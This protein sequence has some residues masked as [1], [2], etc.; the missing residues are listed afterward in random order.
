MLAK[1][2]EKKVIKEIIKIKTFSEEILDSDS[3]SYDDFV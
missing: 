3:K 1:I 2:L